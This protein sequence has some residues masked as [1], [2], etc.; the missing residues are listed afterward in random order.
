MLTVKTVSSPGRTVDFTIS[1][2][3]RTELAVLGVFESGDSAY[4]QLPLTGDGVS[5]HTG[6]CHNVYGI[7]ARLIVDLQCKTH[8]NPLTMA[9]RTLPSC[10]VIDEKSENRY[11][12]T[13]YDYVECHFDTFDFS[14][15]LFRGVRREV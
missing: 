10:Q 14:A 8:F 12:I 7:T 3:R 1:Q 2:A 13:L 5:L 6:N 9:T 11:A 15:I 4:T